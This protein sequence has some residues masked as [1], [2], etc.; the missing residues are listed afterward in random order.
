MPLN[1]KFA[2]GEF[3]DNRYQLDIQIHSGRWGEVF[4]ATDR[5]DD[6]PVAVRFF[7]GAVKADEFV[8]HG[9]R[10]ASL[11]A[12]GLSTPIAFGTHQGVLYAVERWAA[13]QT[14]EGYLAEQGPLGLPQVL[15]V[16]EHLLRALGKA[17]ELN[18]VHGLLRPSKIVVADLDSD[19]PRVTIVD[20]QVWRFFELASGQKAFVESNLSRRILRYSGPEILQQNAVFLATDVYSLGLLIVEMLTGMPALDENHRVVLIAKLLDPTPLE[21]ASDINVGPLFRGFL[22]RLLA[23]NPADR[24]PDANAVYSLFQE[25]R[26]A[27]LAE[28]QPARAS[29]AAGSPNTELFADAPSSAAPLAPAEDD[30]AYDALLAAPPNRSELFDDSSALGDPDSPTRQNTVE[31]KRHTPNSSLI[32]GPALDDFDPSIIEDIPQATEVQL[33]PSPEDVRALTPIGEAR[34][35]IAD[36]PEIEELQLQE[37]APRPASKTP[38]QARASTNPGLTTS[39]TVGLAGFGLLLLLAGAFFL[40]RSPTTPQAQDIALSAGPSSEA[41]EVLRHKIKINTSPPALRVQVQGRPSGM[42]PMTIE[43]RDDEFP[44]QVQARLNADTIL[45]HTLEGPQE[46]LLIEFA[47]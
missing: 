21:L 15:E 41:A 4:R 7:P 20:L 11:R 47:P 28:L 19:R 8:L 5:R 24:L 35:L 17:H 43:V 26:A 38:R 34:P 44:L 2:C 33:F 42:S 39:A 13:G 6:R 16:L 9:R 12:P 29:A 22:A 32:D 25:Q 45:T 36:A 37:E 23:K 1:Q 14:L 30:A 3:V 40:L 46:E 18:I 10:L 27:F 31:P